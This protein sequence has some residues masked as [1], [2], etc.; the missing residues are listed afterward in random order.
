MRKVGI[1]NPEIAKWITQLGHT[2]M[3]LIADAGL[4]LPEN[5]PVVDLSFSNGQIPFLTVLRG[6][7][8]ELVVEN[9]IIT[10]ETEKTS[11]ALF[12]EMYEEIKEYKLI[13]CDHEELKN[14]SKNVKVIIR[15]GEFTPY[16]NIILQAGVPF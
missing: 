3:L 16:A 9:I 13:T 5:V 4:P 6:I 1:I 12:D 7:M 14:I 2:D 15:T 11:K 10:E 8:S